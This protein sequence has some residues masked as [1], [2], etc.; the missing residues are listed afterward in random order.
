MSSVTVESILS[1]V[2]QLP[3]SDRERLIE[4]LTREPKAKSEIF[5]SRIISTNAP[6]V[7]R[8]LEF[9]WLKQHE[10]EYIGQWIA[11]KGDQLIARGATGKEV[12]ASAREQGIHDALVLLVEDPDVPF[13]GV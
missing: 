10:R 5:K 11:L 6:Y 13:I 3:P 2:R 7:D 1:Q 8:T 4:E 12:F 9:A